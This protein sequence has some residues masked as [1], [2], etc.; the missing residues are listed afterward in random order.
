M[1][2]GECMGI[3]STTR[4]VAR[5][6]W[7]WRRT[8]VALVVSVVLL[9]PIV[10]GHAQESPAE[11]GEIRNG[12]AKAIAVVTRIGP[13][14][15]SL[16]LGMTG[17]TAVAQVTNSLAQATSQTVDMGLIGTALTAEGC[18][19]TQYFGPEDLPQPTAV[20]N[21]SGDARVGRDESGT[22]GAPFGIGRMDVQAVEHPAAARAVTSSAAFDLTPVVDVGNGRAEAITHVL[23]GE[24]REARAEVVS[25]IDLGGVVTLSGMRWHARHRTGVAPEA[26]GGFDV[27]DST[28]GG[29]PFPTD[30]AAA[31]ERAV[32]DAL[33]PVGA[34]V[35]FPRVVRLV[36]PTD[37]VRVTPMR[38]ELRDSPAGKTLLGPGLD[39]SREA[40]STLFDELVAAL[41][42]TSSFLLVGDVALSVISG[43]GYLAVEIGGVEA[44]SSDFE[45]VDPFGAA[46]VPPAAPEAPDT[47]TAGAVDGAVATAGPSAPPGGPAPGA[48]SPAPAAGL[49]QPASR[50]GPLE[51]VCESVHPNRDRCSE[52][53]ALAV[54]L[55]AVLATLAVAG[56]DVVRH[57][58]WRDA[59]GHAT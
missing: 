53:A 4:R 44:A 30:D 43:S 28:V 1:V 42:E 54:G 52:G 34:T 40:R 59:A 2:L 45:L 25:S 15:G 50:S 37:L 58:R 5:G 18:R 36:E 49:A 33:A 24:G 29:M 13:G 22:D 39:A 14:V 3:E 11:T 31:L 46:V 38:I 19:G 8:L 7:S 26:V 12:I 21:R 27:G 47:A 16:D 9:G 32:N 20:D 41:C 57:R 23:P 6:V 17:S 35:E 48:T 56:T 51:E 10:S 55:V